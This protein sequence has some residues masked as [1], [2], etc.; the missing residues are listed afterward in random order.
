MCLNTVSKENG[1]R[2]AL[3]EVRTLRE[4]VIGVD[5]GHV[6]TKLGKLSIGTNISNSLLQVVVS[7]EHLEVTVLLALIHTTQNLTLQV[8]AEACI[9]GIINNDKLIDTLVVL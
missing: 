4:G 2:R 3:V 7:D 8:H 6:R 5:T 1:Q 9:S